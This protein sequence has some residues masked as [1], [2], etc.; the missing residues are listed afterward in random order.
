M[1]KKDTVQKQPVGLKKRPAVFT[2]RERIRRPTKQWPTENR[3]SSLQIFLNYLNQNR[4]TVL[5]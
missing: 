3:K 1:N 5:L 4:R 2:S